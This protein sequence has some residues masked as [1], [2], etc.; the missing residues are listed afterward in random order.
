MTGHS[1]ATAQ[2]KKR[3]T[4]TH[5]TGSSDGPFHR[6]RSTTSESVQSTS[7]LMNAIRPRPTTGPGVAHATAIS[8]KS[9]MRNA[10][11]SRLSRQATNA[12]TAA[13][14]PTAAASARRDATNHPS[15]ANTSRTWTQTVCGAQTSAAPLTPAR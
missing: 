8:A 5:A 11:D 14:S 13:T 3:S 9:V 2:G 15:T 6:R 1:T 12:S 7:F 10:G 4:S